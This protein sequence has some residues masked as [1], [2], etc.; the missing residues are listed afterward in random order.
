MLDFITQNWFIISQILVWIAI[1]TDFL[2][3]QFKERKNVLGILTLSS[4]LIALHYWL[5]WEMN[6]FY[7]MLI[8]TISFLVS[9]FTH[10]KKI[11]ILFFIL[12]LIPIVIN[13]TWLVDIVLFISLYIMLFAKFMKDDKFVRLFIMLATLFTIT[14]NIL[15]FT[16]VWV[17]LEVLFLGS[18]MLGYYKHYIKK[19][20]VLITE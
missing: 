10:N 7:L 18:N 19:D 6:A 16:P 14:F 2:S 15:V 11:M 5:L 17:L 13:Y 4:F 1:F 20:K 12:Y 8:S 3:F 9:S